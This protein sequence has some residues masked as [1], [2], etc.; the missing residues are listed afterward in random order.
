MLIMS[1]M[2]T[3]ET[4]PTGKTKTKKETI[5]QKAVH[6]RDHTE[7]WE[8]PPTIHIKEIHITSQCQL[9]KL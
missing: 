7:I 6:L 1:T 5:N 3:I 2:V 8:K 9:K 4:M